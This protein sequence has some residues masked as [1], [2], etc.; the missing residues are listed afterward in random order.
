MILGIGALRISDFGFQVRLARLGSSKDA[1]RMLP[2]LIL[3]GAGLRNSKAAKCSPRHLH[4][5]I[6][7]WQGSV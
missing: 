1:Q 3:N 4:A 6:C 7:T 5:A 2:A